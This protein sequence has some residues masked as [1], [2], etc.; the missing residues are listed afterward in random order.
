MGK[1]QEHQQQSYYIY[2]PYIYTYI[3][4]SFKLNK[5]KTNRNETKRKEN[6]WKIIEEFLEITETE[7][8]NC[9][10]TKY[11]IYTRFRCILWY[12]ITL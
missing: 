2:M 8:E 5:T 1:A 6:E 4:R 12:Y 9:R 10:D 7:G 11:S 3:Y